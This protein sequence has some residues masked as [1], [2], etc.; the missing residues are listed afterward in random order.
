MK[1]LRNL[2]YLIGLSLMISMCSDDADASE[3]LY[4]FLDFC[5]RKSE[6]LIA[7]PA[8][9]MISED[10][11]V[12]YYRLSKSYTSIKKY[13][14]FVFTGTKYFEENDKD[15][16]KKCYFL[17]ENDLSFYCLGTLKDYTTDG[18]GA[19]P[20]IEKQLEKDYNQAYF[21]PS[22]GTYTAMLL[23]WPYRVTAVQNFEITA[24]ASMF[25]ETIGTSLND[26]FRIMDFYPRQVVSSLDNQLKEGLS[27]SHSYNS[28]DK[29]LE[30]VP[31]AAIGMKLQLKDSPNPGKYLITLKLTTKDKKVVIDET[32]VTFR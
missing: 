24:N 32:E 25:G 23:K 12:R 5:P 10:G 1:T 11:E 19:I 18:E 27:S 16:F 20:A 15:E 13:V 21:F 8:E 17:N 30:L 26:H 29:W 14:M 31:Y 2:F 22:T 9:K 6:C 3:D 7:Y 28:I 4:M